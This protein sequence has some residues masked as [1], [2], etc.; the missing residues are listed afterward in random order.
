MVY[1]RCAT[2]VLI[3]VSRLRIFLRKIHARINSC[4]RV[5]LLFRIL[6]LTNMQWRSPS[7]R[8]LAP[9]QLYLSY[10]SN[11]PLSQVSKFVWA[12][13]IKQ[14]NPSFS[15]RQSSQLDTIACVCRFLVSLVYKHKS[16]SPFNSQNYSQSVFTLAQQSLCFPGSAIQ[17]FLTTTRVTSRRPAHIAKVGKSGYNADD[18]VPPSFAEWTPVC[19]TLLKQW[20]ASSP[21]DTVPVPRIW[22]ADYVS[23]AGLVL[24]LLVHQMPFCARAG[25]C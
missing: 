9:A 8:P 14:I 15:W 10:K 25:L 21:V 16:H 1:H 23:L 24:E 3:G 19:S 22:P 20:D 11:V 2:T 5:K 4:W 17:V 7:M 13:P 6:L 18:G 12:F